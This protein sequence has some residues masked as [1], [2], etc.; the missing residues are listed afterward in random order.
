MSEMQQEAKTA[1]EAEVRR[2]ELGYC[3]R[4]GTLRAGSGEELQAVCSH[5]VRVLQ[6]IYG[7]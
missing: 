4:C 7:R 3:P 6:W 1:G 2:V 5:C